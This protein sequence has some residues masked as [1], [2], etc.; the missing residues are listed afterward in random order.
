MNDNETNRRGHAPFVVVIAIAIVGIL[1]VVPWEGCTDGKVKNYNIVGDLAPDDADTA[2]AV[3]AIRVEEVSVPGDTVLATT[4]TTDTVGTARS[5][6]PVELPAPKPSRVGELT[7]I[8]DYSEAQNGLDNIAATLAQGRTARIAV[9]GD[10]YIEGDIMTQDLRALLQ[11]AYGGSGVGFMNMHSEF[12]GFRQSVTQGGNGW[13]CYTAT[14]RGKSEYMGLSE[15]YAVPQGTATAT[16]K[17]SKRVD[18]ARE[19]QRS[20]FLFVSP[21]DAMVSTRTNGGEWTTHSVTGSTAV[22]SIEVDSASTTSFELKTSDT[23]LAALG[24]W[25]DGT[26]RGVSVDCMSSRG[27]PGYSLSKISVDLCRQMSQYVD[28]DLIILEFGINVLSAQQTNYSVYAKNMV[29]AISHLRECYPKARILV[30]GIGDRGE[31]RDGRVRSMSTV[32]AMIEAQRTAARQAGTL[33]WDTRDAMGGED[34]I[35][36]WSKNG[37]ANKDYV[38]LTHKGGRRLATSLA[39]ALKQMIG[40]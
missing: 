21:N 14:K 10:S 23:S 37:F 12:P 39:A 24:V 4:D 15:Q 25:L 28:Y 30:M 3:A 5:A 17:G 36:D 18:H 6:A 20:Q 35:V 33:F 22:Q 13:K 29:N 9:V 34:A 27:I 31:K 7:V 40:Q 26:G 38:H 2:S 1:G 16:Y 11:E 32:P 8:E 19:W